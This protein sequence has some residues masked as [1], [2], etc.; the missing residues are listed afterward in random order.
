MRPTSRVL[1]LVALLG[2]VLAGCSD[3]TGVGAGDPNGIQNL[4]A[5]EAFQL[6]ASTTTKATDVTVSGKQD[7]EGVSADLVSRFAADGAQSEIKSGKS[8][9]GVI[10]TGGYLYVKADKAYWTPLVGGFQAGKIGTRWARSSVDG[11]LASFNAFVDLNSFFRTSARIEK[12]QV[13][14]V[15]GVSALELIDP[16]TNTDSTWAFATDGEALALTYTSGTKT[17]VVFTY[18]EPVIVDAPP[19]DQTVD[20]SGVKPA[21]SPAA[22]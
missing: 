1:V 13:K 9:V 17:N 7:V 15:D 12:G 19:A 4:G 18:G 22:K 11:P 2:M 3:D 5:I 6:G 21:T 8:T 14:D 20:V 10:K 16:P